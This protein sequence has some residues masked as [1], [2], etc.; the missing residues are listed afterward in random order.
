LTHR[1]QQAVHEHRFRTALVEANAGMGAGFYR[2]GDDGQAVFFALQVLGA[3]GGR[4]RSIDHFMS[5]SSHQAF[6]AGG[7]ARTLTAA[8]PASSTQKRAASD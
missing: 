6:F 3:E 7:L 2:R 5:A 4:I 1:V 8:R